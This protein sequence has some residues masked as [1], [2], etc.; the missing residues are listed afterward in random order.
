MI[1]TLE[2][3]G[4]REKVGEKTVLKS[5]CHRKLCSCDSTGGEKENPTME[6]REKEEKKRKYIY[7]YVLKL[8][9]VENIS[10]TG[11]E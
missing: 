2:S 1:A 10:Q 9:T 7:I 5:K 6:R 8:S 4:E 3:Q 11:R